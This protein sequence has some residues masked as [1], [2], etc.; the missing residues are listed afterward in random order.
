MVGGRVLGV[1]VGKGV[2]SHTKTSTD[3]HSSATL[4]TPEVVIFIKFGESEPEGAYITGRL[5]IH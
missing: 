5:F 2:V 1:V 4:F 3:Q